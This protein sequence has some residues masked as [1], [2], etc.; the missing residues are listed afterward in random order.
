MASVVR[1][2]EGTGAM[3]A[4]KG[5]IPQRWG[6]LS[7]GENLGRFIVY[8]SRARPPPKN[9]VEAV[10]TV[11][12]EPEEAMVFDVQITQLTLMASHPQAPHP[13]PNPNPNPNPNTNP[14]PNSAHADGV[15]PAGA[16][17]H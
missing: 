16:Q 17:A 7:G 10:Q 12:K 6:Y 3:E 8:A 4:P 14:N 13:R 1:V 11:S 2:S 9:T 5:E 15:A